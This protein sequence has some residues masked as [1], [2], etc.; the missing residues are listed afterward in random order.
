MKGTK[1]NTRNLT[2]PANITSQPTPPTTLTASPT[3]PPSSF[4]KRTKFIPPKNRKQNGFKRKRVYF[5]N[6][7]KR[8]KNHPS[9][10]KKTPARSLQHEPST[11]ASE[12]TTSEESP[13]THCSVEECVRWKVC[14]RDV[15]RSHKCECDEV[16][17]ERD[18]KVSLHAGNENDKGMKGE[19]GIR[20]FRC[21][22]WITSMYI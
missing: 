22:S 18:W 3:T 6:H 14:W 7:T 16:V 19:L 12:K 9:Y 11:T 2:T 5:D 21:P 8:R 1:Q 10:H 20:F 4:H 17:C 15:K 13:V